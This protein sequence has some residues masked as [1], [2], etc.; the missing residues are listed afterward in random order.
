[1]KSQLSS[2]VRYDTKHLETGASSRCLPAKVKK[3]VTI[4]KIN[5]PLQLSILKKQQLPRS[6]L[7]QI[8]TDEDTYI[9]YDHDGLD[10]PTEGNLA[11]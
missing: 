1:M 6:Q 9:V 2:T 4:N 7:N 3:E 11:Q 8:Q 5:N 10:E